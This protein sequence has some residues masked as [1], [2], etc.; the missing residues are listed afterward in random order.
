MI[1][2]GEPSV[3][4]LWADESSTNLGVR[5]LAEGTSWAVRKA[6][7]SAR[8]EFQS[9]GL[10]PSP[11]AFR[12]PL[13]AKLAGRRSPSALREWLRS[14]DLVIDTGAGDSFASIYG[15]RRQVEM[16]LIRRAAISNGVP[17]IMGPQTVG[18]F[19][20]RLAAQVALWSV[21]D[22]AHLVARD[23]QSEL[24][25]RRLFEVPVSL[26]TDTVFNLAAP[27]KSIS[28]D[29]LINVSGLLWQGSGH[30][31]RSYYRESVTSLVRQLLSSGRQVSLLAHV[32]HADGQLDNDVA[33][34]DEV[35]ALI[36]TGMDE[37]VIP[38]NLDSAREH[39]AGAA[40]VVGSRMHACLNALSVG[41]PS[42]AWA[43]SRKFAPLLG[44]IGWPYVL[45]ARDENSSLVERTRVLCDQ[46]TGDGADLL[47]PVLEEA[48]TR[49]AVLPQLVERAIHG[50]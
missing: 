41:T 19:E 38:S 1:L 32:L 25:A 9:Y 42:V 40:V 34:L 7:P 16:G 26:A 20:G 23:H 17:L 49:A 50:R 18:P 43:Y 4:I 3:L 48:R 14:Y 44:D 6:F 35:M 46:L 5:V 27:K 33:V 12:A 24:E 47:K 36:G 28:H 31:S 45:D 8:V 2:S 13:F 10:G 22:A 11:V 37:P 30:V 29:V 15:M 39:I 21:K